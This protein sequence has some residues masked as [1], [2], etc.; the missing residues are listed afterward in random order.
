VLPDAE[1][2]GATYGHPY[3]QTE[4]QSVIARIWRG[5]V[6]REDA[7]AY[8][9]R[10]LDNGLAAYTAT[11]GNHGA[12]I[13][14]RDSGQC[15]EFVAFSLWDSLDALRAL[16]GDDVETSVRQPED[17]RYLIERDTTVWHYVV[18]GSKRPG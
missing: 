16:T 1:T 14:R 7:D 4:G 2:P 6:R 11:P 12:W 17:D 13:L 15:S 5:V 18:A 3:A 10:A 8:A 9:A